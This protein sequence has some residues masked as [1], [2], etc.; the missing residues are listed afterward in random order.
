MDL[1]PSVHQFVMEVKKETFALV[2]SLCILIYKHHVFF[3]K[4]FLLDG[5]NGARTVVI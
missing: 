5:K 2:S 1:N 3:K 4:Q